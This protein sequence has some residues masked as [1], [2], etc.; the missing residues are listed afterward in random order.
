MEE[1][2]TNINGESTNYPNTS[3]NYRKINILKIF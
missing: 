3:Q 1:N 2:K